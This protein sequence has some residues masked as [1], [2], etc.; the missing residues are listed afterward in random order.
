MGTTLRELLELAGGMK[1]GI[2]LKF[3]TPGRLVDAA[4]SPP[5]TLDVPLDFEGVAARRLDARHHRAA[6]LQRD[7]VGAVGG[8]G[9]GL[10]STSTS[11][12]GKC[13]PCREGTYWLVQILRADRCTGRAPP[14]DL[15]TL[16]DVCDNILG[17]SFCAPR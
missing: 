11:R 14:A 12:C 13:T 17:R 2:P 10:S 16:L 8:H 5:S 3:W 15:D 6:D 7:R 1:D 9:S 4:A